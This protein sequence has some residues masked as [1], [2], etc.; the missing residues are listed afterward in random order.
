MEKMMFQSRTKWTHAWVLAALSLGSS[1]GPTLAHADAP[2]FP[3]PV[4]LQQPAAAPVRAE[5][6]VLYA[7]NEAKGSIDPKIGKMPQL[8]K[9]PF[10]AYNTYRLLDKSEL[11]LDKGG[12]KDKKLAD[13]STLFVT[14]K[15]LQKVKDETKYVVSASIKKPEG[16]SVLPLLEVTAKAG[17]IFFVAGQKYKDGVLVIG[18]RVLG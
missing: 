16:K 2:G 3:R 10:S 7:T 1:M 15:D 4:P 17:E 9:P 18:I 14:L 13:D 12:P 5:I 8:E 6:I 11:A